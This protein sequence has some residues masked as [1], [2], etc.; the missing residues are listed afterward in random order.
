MDQDSN[1][2][3][4]RTRQALRIQ[5][6]LKKILIHLALPFLAVL[7]LPRRVRFVSKAAGRTY[8]SVVLDQGKLLILV[9]HVFLGLLNGTG[10]LAEVTGIC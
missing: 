2:L 7:P 8:F 6:S 5:D 9:V 1:F 3:V 10:V 4:K